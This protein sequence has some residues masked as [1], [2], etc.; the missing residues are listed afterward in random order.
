MRTLISILITAFLI[1]LPLS[2]ADMPEWVGNPYSEYDKSLYI[3][4]SGAGATRAAAEENA[5]SSIAAVFGVSVESETSTYSHESTA[6]GVFDSM[7]SSSSLSVSTELSGV[8]IVDHWSDGRSEYA[9]AIMDKDAASAYYIGEIMR[10]SN[11]I[12]GKLDQAER[13]GNALSLYAAAYS[14]LPDAEEVDRCRSILAVLSPGTMLSDAPGVA[15]IESVMREA[16]RDVGICIEMVSD[17]GLESS[18]EVDLM[19]WLSLNGLLVVE[20]EDAR[21]ILEASIDVYETPGPRGMVY[22]EYDL[23]I[24]ITDGD[25]GRE[26]LAY[27]HSGREG[28]RTFARAE[29]MVENT[30]SELIE[31]DFSKSFLAVF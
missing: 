30:L 18:L 7:A 5:I 9:L 11:A 19:Q 16:A 20:P 14:L 3:A 23:D 21:Y 27:T 2:A 24:V 26:V 22:A 4:A 25:T 28:Q 29:R 1:V 31:D 13:S 12:T 17:S 15:Y 8:T 6:T 10:L